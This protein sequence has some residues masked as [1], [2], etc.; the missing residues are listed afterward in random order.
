MLSRGNIERAHRGGGEGNRALIVY[1]SL[2]A[3]YKEK[4]VAMYGDPDKK[5]KETMVK[6]T[7]KLDT[8]AADFYAGYT[9]P[10]KTGERVHL[11]N[12]LQEDYTVNASVLKILLKTANQR[13]MLRH[14]LGG[15]MA[16]VWE[17]IQQQ[18]EKLRDQ[19]R[20]TLPKNA[21]RLK[22]RVGEFQSEGYAS[23]IS[24]KVGNLNTLK[25]T[26]ESAR[27]L[28]AMKRSVSPKMSDAEILGRYNA[29][30]EERGWKPLKSEGSLHSWLMSDAV[31]CQWWDAHYGDV[32]LR[33]KFGRKHQTS[34]P[35]K[36]DALWYGDGTK[37][38]L[39][40]RGEDGK[41]Y[42]TCVYEVVDAYSEMLLGYHISDSEDSISQYNA[43]RMAVQVS[44]HKA[45]EIVYDNQGGHQKLKKGGFFS[46]ISTMYHPTS[47]YNPQSKTIE[48]I[49]GR[50]QQQVLTKLWNFTGQN[51]SATK[52][53][54]RP[55]L[56]LVNANKDNLPTLDELR[57]IYSE[58]RGKWN[59]M[60]HPATGV[61]RKEMYA[62]SENE[63]TRA[64]STTDMINMFWVFTDKEIKFTASG[65][66]VTIGKNRP[67]YEVYK[68]GLP[69]HGW[70]RLHQGEKFIV[71][72][73]PC[74]LRS[75]RLYRKEQD[76]D[77]RYMTH[78]E[79]YFKVHRARQEQTAQ[80]KEFLRREREATERDVIDAYMT[81]RKAEMDYG[82]SPEQNGLNPSKLRTVS[83][84]EQKIIDR[85][86]SRYGRDPEETELGRKVKAVSLQDYA[87]RKEESAKQAEEDA[88]ARIYKKM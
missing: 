56:E 74:D 21:A 39:Y 43:F 38:N 5:L 3:R 76:G 52:D 50:F 13:R 8:A 25:I 65:I 61:S 40:Y 66:A 20:H 62:T 12:E 19:Y 23:L 70:R 55:N 29:M 14:S 15:S 30:A 75:V 80:E 26:G 16:G 48:S 37:L 60:P 10:S 78:A 44:G 34:L 32:A 68:E 58:A 69:D 17:T 1:D 2:P 53:S 57:A 35:G 73:D 42:T 67:S 79:P 64:V 27:M 82:T 33:Q 49:F 11:K 72:Y 41:V 46:R 87:K 88:K 86:L 63:E 85:R 7:M 47:P 77:L 36:R 51:M 45:Y 24:G 83:K 31:A 22:Q 71:A 59:S 81:G 6:E 18:S 84:D 54:G 9:Y 28:I 4:Y